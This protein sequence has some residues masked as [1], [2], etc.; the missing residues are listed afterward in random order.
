MRRLTF[1]LVAAPLFFSLSC[2]RIEKKPQPASVGSRSAKERNVFAKDERGVSYSLETSF[3]FGAEDIYLYYSSDGKTWSK[4]L[5]TGLSISQESSLSDC[6]VSVSGGKIEITYDKA[7]DFGKS[8]Q[9]EKVSFTLSDLERDT[10][11]DGLTDIEEVRLRTDPAR[12]DTDGDGVKDSEDMNPLVAKKKLTE[13]QKIR[14]AAFRRM[15]QMRDTDQTRVFGSSLIIVQ[16]PSSEKQEFQ[17]H[18]FFVLNLTEEEV[19]DFKSQ[20]GDGVCVIY[21]A[22]ESQFGDH[23][24][25]EFQSVWLPLAGRGWKVTLK[26]NSST[27]E[28]W[29]VTDIT[30]EWIS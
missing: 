17:G 5:F 29:G 6:K 15:V 3:K 30:L 26:K 4:P 9:R 16:T 24:Q 12:A 10:D 19:Q 8:S 18:D 14:Q 21:F 7:I 28:G 20:F 23:A 13:M 25:V 22:N 11:R 2:E 1:I 27:P